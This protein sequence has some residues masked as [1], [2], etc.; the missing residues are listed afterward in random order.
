MKSTVLCYQ[1]PG[2]ASPTK[3]AFYLTRQL[4]AH[5][6]HGVKEERTVTTV[7]ASFEQMS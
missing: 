4:L 2:P 7:N 5:G 1:S 6:N 3:A